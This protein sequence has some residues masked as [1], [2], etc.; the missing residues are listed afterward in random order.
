MG[1]AAAP[2]TNT[3]APEGTSAATSFADTARDDQAGS[4]LTSAMYHAEIERGTRRALQSLRLHG[5]PLS[6]FTRKIRIL[7]AE[8]GV[9]FEF[10]RPTNLLDADPAA[11]GDNPLMRVPTLVHGDITV[12]ESDHIARYLVATFDRK[13]WFEVNTT[14]VGQLNRLAVANGVM[15]NEVVLIL[16]KRGGLTDVES[17]A[18]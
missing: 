12:I 2:C 4:V 16:A 17:V 14:D 3:R 11:Y 1:V 10:V 18:Y 9:S 7:L 13:D 15:S 6:H 8:M 5:T